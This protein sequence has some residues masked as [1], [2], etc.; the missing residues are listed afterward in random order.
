MSIGTIEQELAL[1]RSA[2]KGVK[3]GAVVKNCHHD[4]LLEILT[5]PPGTRIA[6]IMSN[7]LLLGSG[8]ACKPLIR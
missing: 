7:P 6:Y 4:L 5:E 3:V 2:F 1:C 8:H